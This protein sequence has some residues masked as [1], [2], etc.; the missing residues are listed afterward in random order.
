V[1]DNQRKLKHLPNLLTAARIVMAPYI[2][3]LMWTNAYQT[4]LLWFVAAAVTDALDGFFARRFQASSR[5]GAYFDPVA[6]KIL[7]SGSFLVLALAGAIPT[8]LAALVLG[9]DVLLLA[10]AAVALQAGVARDLT[11]SVWGKWSTVSQMVYLLAVLAGIP[12]VALATLTAAITLWSGA[13]YVW[14]FLSR[15]R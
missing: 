5:L 3:Y 12:S 7:L 10:G 1:R 11:P 13:A 14:R 15:A 6:D 4:A 2:F 9:R 8:S